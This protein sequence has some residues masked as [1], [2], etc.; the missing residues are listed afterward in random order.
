MKWSKSERFI[1][2]DADSN[3]PYNPQHVVWLYWASLFPEISPKK[4]DF[5]Y[6]NQKQNII[7]NVIN[8]KQIKQS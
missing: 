5:V 6:G 8:K 2:S 1:G 4:Q 7:K 3:Q